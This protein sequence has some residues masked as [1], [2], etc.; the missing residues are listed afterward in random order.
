MIRELLSSELNKPDGKT[1]FVNR[2]PNQNLDYDTGEQA[3]TTD[4]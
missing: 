1:E 4:F 3:S 2:S